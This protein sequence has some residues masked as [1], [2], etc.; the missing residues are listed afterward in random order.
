[1]P[2]SSVFF[3]TP[4]FALP[5][6]DALLH[7]G[8]TPLAVVCQPDRPSGRGLERKSPPA[9]YWAKARGVPVFQPEKLKN[10]DFLEQMRRYNPD[11]ALVAAFGQLVPKSFLELPRFGFINVHPSLLPRYRGAAPIQ[12]TL[13]NGDALTGVTILQVTPRLDD[14]DILLQESQPLLPETT[15][16]ELHDRLAQLG[17]R[18]SV[19][20]L[21]LYERGQI[22][23]RPQDGSQVVW[24]R[25]LQKEDGCIDWSAS[26]LAIHNR[27]RGVQPWPGAFTYFNGKLFKIHRAAPETITPS[28]AS[29]AGSDVSP[30]TVFV[31]GEHLLVR[32]GDGWLRLLEVQLEGKKRMEAKSFLVG[33]TV[34]MGDNFNEKS[35]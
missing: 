9:K 23:P 24:A 17:G 20:A 10:S 22:A 34:R 14:G 16:Q 28:L 29:A 2:I 7:A 30:G 25:A 21:E 15:A 12:W 27:I 1:M 32:T 13:I 5:I 33:R 4:D 11:I 31:D 3:G 8:R 18:L 35:S 26:T 6:L 19:Q